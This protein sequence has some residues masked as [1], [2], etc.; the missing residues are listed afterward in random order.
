MLPAHIVEGVSTASGLRAALPRWAMPA[1]GEHRTL[2]F[3]FYFPST[4]SCVSV[5]HH[6]DKV[7]EGKI[8]LKEETVCFGLEGSVH[9]HVALLFLDCGEAEGDGD[10]KLLTYGGQRGGERLGRGMGET[11]RKKGEG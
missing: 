6:C 5:S 10:T 9:A 7:P 2:P 4:C 1:A 8:P 11:E 3:P